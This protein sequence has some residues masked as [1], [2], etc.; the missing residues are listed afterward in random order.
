VVLEAID[1]DVNASPAHVKGLDE[2]RLEQPVAA[3]DAQ[4]QAP[5]GW[6]QADAPVRDVRD[7]QAP[8]RAVW[9]VL[10]TEAGVPPQEGRDRRRRRDP[11]RTAR[12][13]EDRSHVVLDR[14]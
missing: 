11:P 1:F 2:E 5:S 14:L 6:R 9:N 10:E 8:A 4:R 3:G 7:E 12:R 13:A